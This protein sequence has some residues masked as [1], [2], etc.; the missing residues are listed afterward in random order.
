MV[1]GAYGVAGASVSLVGGCAGD[2]LAM[3]STAQL[4]DGEVLHG[5]LVGVAVGSDGPIGVGIGHGW[6]RVGEPLVV[7]ESDGTTIVSLDGQPALDRYL[8]LAGAEPDA[9]LDASRWQQVTMTHC[10]GL[11]RPG[12]EEVRAVLSGNYQDRTLTCSD[13]PQGTTVWLMQGDAGTVQEGT[14]AAAEQAVAA[15]GGVT[16]RGVIAFDCVARRSILGPDG[17]AEEARLLDEI[18]AGAPVGGFYTYGEFARTHGSRGVHNATL[19]LLA[20]G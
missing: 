16:P 9:V 19:V 7:T 18:M 12:G 11:P 5:R 14:R 20:L 13:V 3:R 4:V 6:R 10:F 17:T 8:R 2:E 1:R 15:L